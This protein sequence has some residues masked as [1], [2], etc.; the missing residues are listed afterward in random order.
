[1]SKIGNKP[2]TVPSTVSVRYEDGIVTINGE[3]GEI[4]LELPSLILFE[5]NNGI[6]RLKRKNDTKKAKALHGLFRSLLQNAVIGVEKPW[7][8]TLKVVGTGY[9][10]KLKDKDLV[11][12]LGYSHPVVF[13]KPEGVDFFVEGSDK[14]RIVGCDKQKVGEIASRIRFLKKPDPYK[15]KGI[16]YEDEVLKLK[17]G[18]KA[19]A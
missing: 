16:R 18:K 5:Q 4:R 11:F 2:I 9:K 10:V 3:K 17:P 15:G 13:K 14:V 7:T 1:M 8:K 19:K 6:I 12:E